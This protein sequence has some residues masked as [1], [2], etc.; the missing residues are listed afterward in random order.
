[1]I[2]EDYYSRVVSALV[3][4]RTLEV[5]GGSGNLTTFVPDVISTDIL[6]APW[7]SAAC[8][9]Q[10]L[11]FANECFSNVVG[12]DVLH[13]IERPRR[14]FAEAQRVLA[15]GGRIVLIE[16]AITP[17]SRL[18]YRWFHPESIDMN[19]D[20]LADGPLDPHREPFDANQAIPTLLWGTHRHRF[21]EMFPRL[22]INHVGY[23]S[24]MA[25]P[26]S[27]GFRAWSLIPSAAIPWLLNVERVM[28]PVIGRLTAF[29][30]MAV[31]EKSS[32]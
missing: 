9:G 32:E 18:L 16:P 31:L 23:I 8:D 29:R 10:A 20:P 22:R 4:G 1:M 3:V 19:A 12:V 26:L 11:P 6:P 24:L 14:F 7:L 27:G 15:R 25:Y 2:Y 13:H 30:V 5:G 21:T 17:I 28:A